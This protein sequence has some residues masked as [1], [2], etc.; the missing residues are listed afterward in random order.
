[1]EQTGCSKLKLAF[2]KANHGSVAGRAA[3]FVPLA[4]ALWWFLL[5]GPSLWLLRTL[6]WLPLVLFVS[7]AGLDPVKVNPETGDWT[8]NVHVNTAARNESGGQS[9]FIDSVEIDVTANGVAAYASSWFCYLGLALSTRPFSKQRA[10]RMFYGLG[11]QTM[12]NVLSLAACAYLMGYGSAINSPNGADSRLWFIKYLDHIN[13][14]VLPFLG[15]FLVAL[16][17]H[18]EWRECVGMQGATKPAPPSVKAS[19]RVAESR[20][21]I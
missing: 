18:P 1:M 4:M 9:Q 7:P 5:K 21:R 10:R 15:P 3:I 13:S 20:H 6:V 16:L 14:L 17:V 11:I 8:F 12:V 19:S 2:W